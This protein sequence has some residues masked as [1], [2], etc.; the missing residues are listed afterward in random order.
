MNNGSPLPTLFGDAKEKAAHTSGG[1]FKRPPPSATQRDSID[2]VDG[3][4][5]SQRTVSNWVAIAKSPLH[6]LTR[7]RKAKR[8]KLKSLEA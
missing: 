4:E 2:H 1:S 5:L 3:E 7:V 8:P 6:S